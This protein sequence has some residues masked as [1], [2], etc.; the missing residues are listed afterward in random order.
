MSRSKFVHL[1]LHT[2]YSLLDG[3]P[4]IK[5]LVEK[6]KRLSMP[7]VAITDHGNMYGIIEFYQQALAN[8]IKP[9]L[10][11]EIYLS[12]TDR[13]QKKAKDAFHLTLL[14]QNYQGYKNLMKIVSIG[15]L[16][17]FYY[18]PRV[19]LEV[20]AKY[21]Q[22]LIALSGCGSSLLNRLLVDDKFDKAREYLNRFL[23]IFKDNFYIELQRHHNDLAAKNFDAN[24]QIYQRL[25]Q[26]HQQEVRAEKG[27]LKL[28]KEFGVPLVATNDVHYLD[29]DHAKVQDILVC[30]QTGRKVDEVNRLRMLDN[31]DYYF[32]SADEMIKDFNDLPE[33]VNNTLKIADS[34]DIKITLGQWFFPKFKL[35]PRKTAG[36][37]LKEKVYQGARK[38]YSTSLSQEIK[39]RLDYELNIIDTKGYSAYFL[40]V[41]DM[42]LFAKKNNIITN[43]RGSAAGSLVAY[44]L[45]ISSVDPLKFQLPFERFL[46]PYRPLPPDIDLD[47]SDI[48]REKIINYLAIKYGE[49]KE[50]QIC[51][52]GR[53]LARASVRDVGRVLGYPYS[54]PDKLAKLIPFGSQG[55]PMTIKQALEIS[56]PLKAEYDSNSQA[57]EILDLAQKVEGRARHISVHAAAVVVAPTEITDFT[58][59]QYDP[60]GSV[61]IT[62]YEMHASE[63]VGLIKF[64]LLGLTNLSILG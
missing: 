63:A 30:I 17:G 38:I 23:E 36:E 3:L 34:V 44:C 61:I 18:R 50:A 45:G 52:F 47:V 37:V 6:V 33:A 25:I 9:I 1:H 16:E 26:L 41:Q 15:Y 5:E 46:N 4:M 32:K 58:P 19:D 35:P 56:Q 24:S 59:V 8:D 2:E 39:K 60:N 31:P 20:L 54:V 7:A 14:A 29:P 55:F 21:G 49:E 53:M 28:A 48:D 62:Q 12:A 13:K 43:T 10:G 57:K 64:D 51:T 40:I 42:V 27:L 22:G 11:S